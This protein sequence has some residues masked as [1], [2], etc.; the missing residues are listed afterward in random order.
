[1]PLWHRRAERFSRVEAVTGKDVCT[2][3]RDNFRRRKVI[4]MAE[5]EYIRHL[6]EKEGKS[7][8]AISKI[9]NLAF[10]T[11]KK[12]ACRDNW[13]DEKI[14]NAQTEKHPKLGEYIPFV[15]KCLAEDVCQPRKQR[16]TMKRIYTRLRDERGYTGSYSS[17]RRYV[18]KKQYLMG[19]EVTKGYLQIEQPKGH[20]Q[21]DFGEFKYCDGKG[22]EHK[23]HALTLTFPY[24]N[25]GFTQVFK[26]ENQECLLEGMKR[27]FEYIGGVPLRIRTDNM[28]SA[29]VRILSGTDRELSD[30]FQKFKLHYR[31][32]TDFCNPASGNEKGNVENKVGYNRRNFLVPVP[33][34][35]Q[36]QEFNEQLFEKCEKDGEREHYRHKVPM[37]ELWEEERKILLT[38]PPYPYEIFKLETARINKYGFVLADG[39]KYGIAPEFAG[40]TAE[41]RIYYDRVDIY[42]EH[43]LLKSYERCYG[44]EEERSDWKQYI[45][46]LCKKPGAVEHTRFFEQMP[47]LWQ[48]H[49]A[50]T[51]GRERKTALTLLLEIVQDG[52]EDLCNTVLELAELYGRT[53]G[54]SLRHF[55]YALANGENH[56]EPLVLSHAVPLNYNPDLS[57]YD[58]LTGGAFNG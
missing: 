3:K 18:R 22:G 8:R 54:E 36:F 9:T 31:F 10:E 6:W 27:V 13:N 49:L 24:S 48:K 37:R 11:V 50:Q 30:G 41:V 35:E 29:V 57:I 38:L 5:V 53:D 40:K 23:G 16:H 33:E 45:K 51:Q 15:D 44:K 19:Q 55:Y 25:M 46:T 52:R 28:T 26:G 34:I 17:V 43:E 1:M 2:Q 58:T 42:F 7:L 39:K 20:S 21:L 47:E 12:Y 32:E 56:P 4:K 14:P